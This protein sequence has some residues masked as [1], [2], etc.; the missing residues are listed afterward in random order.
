MLA[1]DQKIHAEIISQKN[2]Y[3]FKSALSGAGLGVVF[4]ESVNQHDWEALL[5]NTEVHYAI[6]EKIAAKKIRNYYTR[7]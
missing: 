3:V 2:R 4:G 7:K 1:H 5:K 6:Q